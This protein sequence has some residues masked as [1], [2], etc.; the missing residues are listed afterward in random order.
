MNANCPIDVQ[1]KRIPPSGAILTLDARGFH[2][3]LRTLGCTPDERGQFFA[4]KPYVYRDAMIDVDS[5]T[6][7][8]SAL[9]KLGGPHTV[10][11]ASLYNGPPSMDRLKSLVSK[12]NLHALAM[13]IVDHYRPIEIRVSLVVKPVKVIVPATEAH[14]EVA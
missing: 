14:A 10:D 5:D 9:L 11:L 3:Y 7:T 4:G 12:A 8:A 2:D 1:I 13:R 6:L